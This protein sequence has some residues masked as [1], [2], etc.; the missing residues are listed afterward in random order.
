[1]VNK[2]F[3]ENVKNDILIIEDDNEMR[4]LISKFLKKK[5]FEIKEARTGDEAFDILQTFTPKLII[6]D[7]YLDKS[8]I[9]GLTM[10]EML[11]QKL[12]N[13]HIIVISGHNNLKF[14]LKSLQIGIYD[15]LEKPFNYYRL[16]VSV[17]RACESYNIIEENNLL[18]SKKYFLSQYVGESNQAVRVHKFIHKVSRA[19]ARCFIYG[20]RGSGK[21]LIAKSI[22]NM[23]ENRKGVFEKYIGALNADYNTYDRFFFDTNDKESVLSKT[24]K[25][26]L[27]IE[28]IANVPLNIQN[29]FAKI[30]N[31]NYFKNNKTNRFEELNMNVIISA[32]DDPLVLMQDGKLS[33]ELFNLL[34]NHVLKTPNICDMKDDF[35]LFIKKITQDI[36]DDCDV[37]PRIFSSEAIAFL[38]LYNWKGG[39]RELKAVV[40]RVLVYEAETG[41]VITTEL[42]R[43]MAFGA[44]ANDY[45]LEDDIPISADLSSFDLKVDLSNFSNASLKRVRTY[46]EIQ[47]I[48]MQM[49]RFNNNISKTATAIDMERSALHRKLKSLGIQDIQ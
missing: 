41:P 26:T 25:G 44:D 12:P 6:T 33:H 11:K 42:S 29:D 40:E 2:I 31:D 34:S 14:S 47:F 38:Q 10:I 49:Q 18:K 24:Q 22:H 17:L 30:L 4:D 23:S 3:P 48:K 7:L 46:C 43:F 36:I 27:F 8:T 13:V 39:F 9:N 16:Y 45:G 19:S 20:S 15:F 32:L 5:G 1:M 28:N 21:E 35:P 37:K